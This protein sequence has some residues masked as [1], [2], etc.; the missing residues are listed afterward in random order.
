MQTRQS[1]GD[2]LRRLGLSAG[3]TVL[4]HSSLRSLGVVCGG[5]VAA[6]QALMD[7]I[8]PAGTL[9]VPAHTAAHNRDPASWTDPLFEHLMSDERSCQIVRDH[10]P[11]FDPAITPSQGV[12]AI[13]E[14]VRTWPG[15]RRSGHPQT[16]FAAVGPLA[17]R[18]VADHHLDSPVGEQ[19]PLARLEELDAVVLLLGVGMDRNTSFHLAEYRLADPP[20]RVN[21]CA[22]VN[23]HG[24]RQWITYAGIYLNDRDFSEIGDAFRTRT[25]AVT[26]GH[27]G[28]APAMLFPIRSAVEF[29][30]DWMRT[31]RHPR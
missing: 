29:A 18:I 31:H 2:D 24:D 10:L 3:D 15:A 20:R 17:G 28:D 11:G 22:V 16:S 21:A 4:V 19:S 9:V 26:N 23:S 7:A 8:G 30:V 14:A 13:A 1:L 5:A 12:G 6:V 25:T 27:V